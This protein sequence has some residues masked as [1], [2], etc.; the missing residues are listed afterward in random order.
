VSILVEY[1]P[2]NSGGSWWLEDKDWYALEKGGWKIAWADKEFVYDDDGNHVLEEDGTPRIVELGKG[3]G[4]L[5]VEQ[6][7]KDRKVRYLGALARYAYKRFPTIK[8]ALLEFENLTGQDVTAE[9]CNCCGPP[10]SFNWRDEN[11]EYQFCSGKDCIE[12][13]YG[14]LPKSPR[15]YIEMMR[16]K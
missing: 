8:D 15:E 13:M 1:N 4:K 12:I 10:H 11:D 16:S 5:R 3:N 9:G 14:E 6:K 2:N 7:G